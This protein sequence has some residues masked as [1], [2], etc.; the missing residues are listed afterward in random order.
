MRSLGW[1]LIQSDWCL[2]K[3]G[4]FGYM[5][6]HQG[7]MCTEERHCKETVRWW[8]PASQGERPQEKPQPD[9]PLILDFQPPEL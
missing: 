6:R 7:C 8:P 1:A 4:T 2:C 3:T 5:E 9:D